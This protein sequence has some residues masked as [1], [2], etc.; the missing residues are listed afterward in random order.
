MDPLLRIA[1]E[2]A[3]LRRRIASLEG[4]ERPLPNRGAAFPA[5]NQAA[6]SPFFRTDL[7]LHCYYNGARWL[8]TEM[9]PAQLMINGSFGSSGATAL[10]PIRSDYAPFIVRVTTINIVVTTNDGGN[11]WMINLRGVNNT[12]TA[13]S[14]IHLVSTAS[15]TANTWA[16]VESGPNTTQTPA[17]RQ[18]VDVDLIKIGAPG[19]IIPFMTVYYRLIVT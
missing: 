4:Q 11:Y 5:S 14:Q 17:N 12:Y 2:V 18:A 19:A 3:A 13:A 6:Q 10:T 9:F 1:E 16:T 7:G 8:T 15:Q